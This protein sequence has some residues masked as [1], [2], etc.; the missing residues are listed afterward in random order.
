[1]K[2]SVDHLVISARVLEE[3]REFAEDLFGVCLSPKGKHPHMGT[4]NQLVSLGADVYL[5]IIAIDPDAPEPKQPR[6]FD[7]DNFAGAPRLTNWVIRTDDM[8]QAC[9]HLPAGVGTPIALQRDKFRWQ[10]AVPADGK[11]PFDGL[12]PASIQWDGQAHPTDGLPDV[13]LRLK[14]L[15][16]KHPSADIIHET[17]APFMDLNDI[18]FF[19]AANA[20]LRADIAT[21]KGLVTLR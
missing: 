18:R 17:L 14:K 10:M 2:L 1:M 6:W 19:S 13:G 3:G 8:A 5:E 20:G 16:L 21:S 7:L 9:R 11:L 15:T 12:Y 4:H